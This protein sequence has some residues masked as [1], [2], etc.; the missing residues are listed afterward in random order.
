MNIELLGDKVLVQLQDHPDHT[1]TAGGILNPL[2]VNIESDAGRPKA[3]ASN[4]K[5]LAKGKVLLISPL[6]KERIPLLEVGDEVYV[7]PTTVSQDFHFSLKRASLVEDF[8]GVISIPSSL[9]E[10]KIIN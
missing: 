9:V 8:D 4:K 3:K 6:A 7:A 10:A 2:F 5:Y 1:I